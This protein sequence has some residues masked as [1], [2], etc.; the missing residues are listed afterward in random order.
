MKISNFMK[1]TNPLIPGYRFVELDALRGIAVILVLLSHYTFAYD[2]FFNL[3][4]Q[5]IFTFHFGKFG[6]QLFL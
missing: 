3:L 4:N 1:R 5:H 6:V 2:N